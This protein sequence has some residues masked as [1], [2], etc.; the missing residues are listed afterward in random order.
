VSELTKLS[1]LAVPT[2]MQALNRAYERTGDSRTDCLNR[3]IQTYDAL[4]SVQ[5]G[6]TVTFDDMTFARLR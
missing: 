2:A 6:Q 3:A 1:F 5:V 4:M